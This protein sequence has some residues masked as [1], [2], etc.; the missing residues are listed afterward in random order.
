MRG[1][2]GKIPTVCRRGTRRPLRLSGDSKKI[3][4]TVHNCCN[5]A[6]YYLPPF[7]VYKSK[8]HLYDAWCRGGPNNAVYTSSRFG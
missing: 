8:N 3:N 4:Y 2:Q 7:I 1:D 5:A 6:S